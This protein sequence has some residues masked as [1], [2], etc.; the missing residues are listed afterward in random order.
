MPIDFSISRW[1]DTVAAGQWTRERRDLDRL[2]DG[3]PD[4]VA[5]SAP[6]A[7]VHRL[8][9]ALFVVFED[10]SLRV[11]AA[12]TRLAPTLE[13]LNFAAQQ[14]LDEARHH[15]MFRRRLI[16]A[17]AAAGLDDAA[18]TAPILIPPLRSFIDRCYEVADGGSFIEGMVLM[19]LVLEG[20]AHPLYAYEERYWAPLDP[21]LAR[22]VRAAF[23]DETRHVAFGAD[24][25]R[26]L[27]AEDPGR[28]AKVATLCRDAERAMGE[29]FSVYI[30]EFVGLF[31]A[32]A[33][34]HPTLFAGAELA[35][36]RLIAET[37][38]EDQVAAIEAS[39]RREHARL[40]ARAGLD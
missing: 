33:R 7:E 23:T 19:N 14:T 39:I 13:A 6:L 9:L 28:R 30:R 36:G 12:L 20:M 2:G 37:P 31:D 26:R 25:V 15:E 32:V 24:L 8:D 3:L 35:P 17:S 34:L 10:A 18:A 40:I 11:S 27:L 4:V 1:V 21:Y 5:T 16:A 38:Y 29:I 22:L